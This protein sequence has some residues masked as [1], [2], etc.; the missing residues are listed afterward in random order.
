MFDQVN[1]LP[2][3]ALV[4]HAA[5][6]FVPLLALGALVYALAAPWR[7]RLGWA[8]A[9]LAVVAPLSTF[10]AKESGEE[11]YNRLVASGLKG[12]GLE[13][14]NDHMDYGA[15]TLWFALGLGVVSLVM[16]ALTFR[17]NRSLPM[18]AQVAFVVLTLVL[19]AGSGYYIF[20][21]GDTGATAVWGRY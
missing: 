20:Q 1:G 17:G 7:P 19:A 18:L 10:V 12:K 15:M 6:V 16:V 21:T 8:V 11:L 2:V 9:L 3:H 13:I 5:V 14:L 4:L